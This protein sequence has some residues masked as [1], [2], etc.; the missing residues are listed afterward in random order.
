MLT[1]KFPY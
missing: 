1:S